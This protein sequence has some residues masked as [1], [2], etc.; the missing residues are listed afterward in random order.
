MR[1]SRVLLSAATVVALGTTVLTSGS[2]VAAEGH[3]RQAGKAYTVTAK[4]N[5]TELVLGQRVK[6]TGKVEPAAP[7]RTVVLQQKIGDKPWKDQTTA[8]INRRGTY[9]V[10]DKPTTLNPRKYRVVKAASKKH[11]RGVSESLAVSVYQWHKV[12]DL[13]VRDSQYMYK[14]K[15]LTI[16][17]VEYPTSLYGGY[18]PADDPTGFMDFNLERR[19]IRLTSTFGM[20]DDAD[21]GSSVKLDVVGDGTNLYSGTFSLLESQ[22]KTIDLHGVFR[23]GFEYEALTD[24][25]AVPAV[26]SPEVL[27]SF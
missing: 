13:E 1:K 11:R 7:G 15:S 10:V 24:A 19:C 3:A 2:G 25:A 18:Y 22:A 5:R 9:T 21:T 23:L 20:S 16:D 14:T 27:C 12:Y 6:I 26:G 17:T 4:A 8:T